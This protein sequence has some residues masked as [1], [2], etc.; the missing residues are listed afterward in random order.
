MSVA[1]VFETH[2]ISEDNEAG[3]ATGWLPGRLSARG[4]E[5]ARELGERRARDGLSAVFT[6]D[7][8]RAVETAEI[9]FAESPLAVV[10]DPRLRE[11]NYGGLNG[12]PSER[13]GR[14]RSRHLDE[15]YPDGES[16]REAV[17]RVAGFLDELVRERDGER[18][19]IIGHVA[20]RW[21]L[22][23]AA[24]GAPL[25]A[26][27]AAPFEWRPGWEYRLERG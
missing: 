27:V 20:T 15:P 22:E 6:S 23:R 25:E 21:A 2:S 19:L 10:R 3:I 18:V 26:L 4:R 14:D 9:A 1:V 16:W 13:L 5:L 17:E 12:M 24:N 8:A 11:C 7:L